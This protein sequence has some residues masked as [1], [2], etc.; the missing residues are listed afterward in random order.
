MIDSVRTYCIVE[1]ADDLI[2]FLQRVFDAELVAR[3]PTPDEKVMHAEMRV[4]DST[5]ELADAGGEWKPLAPPQHVY[6]D[7]VDAVY[8]RALEAGARSLYEPVEQPYGDREA[9]VV[10]RR[11][12]QWFLG[13]H[14][15]DGGPRRPGFATLTAALRVRGLAAAI[16]F[17]GRAFDATVVSSTRENSI[18]HAEIRI[19]QTLIEVSEAR[20]PW[21]PTRGAFHVFASDCDAV[22]GAALRAGATTLSEPE[23]KPYGER[24]GGVTDAWGH[25][26]YIATPLG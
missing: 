8:R 11:S 9:G 4:G 1:G 6:V 15:G 23:D 3:F 19:G 20:E 10:D 7:D 13:T 22:Y 2:A 26:W 21:D 18:N 17:L 25:Q 24:S 14:R 5:L 12:I 16:D